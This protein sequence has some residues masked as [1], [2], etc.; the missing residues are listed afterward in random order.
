MKILIIEDDSRV[1]EPI[2]RGLEEQSFKTTLAYNG[3]SGKKLA[4]QHTVRP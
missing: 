3:L 4:E 2:Q 1:A